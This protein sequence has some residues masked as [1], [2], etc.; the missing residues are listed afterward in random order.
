[1]RV[2]LTKSPLIV[3]AALAA[4]PAAA[5][6]GAAQKDLM[7]KGMVVEALTDAP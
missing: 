6:Q 2:S 1:M 7:A 5:H 4:L 3:A